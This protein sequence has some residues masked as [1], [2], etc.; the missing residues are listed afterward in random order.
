[1]K[2]GDI[3]VREFIPALRVSDSKPGLYDTV[4]SVFYTNAG[5]GEFLYA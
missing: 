2:F 5:S 4:N 1:M 3:L